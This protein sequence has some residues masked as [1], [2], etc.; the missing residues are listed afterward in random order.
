MDAQAD[1]PRTLASG[2]GRGRTISSTAQSLNAAPQR[3]AL[4]A[5]LQQEQAALSQ[6]IESLAASLPVSSTA[7]AHPRSGAASIS[8]VSIKLPP[9]WP[10][11]PLIWFAQAEAMFNTRRITQQQTKFDYVISSLSHEYAL[12]VRDLLLHPPAHNPYDVLKEK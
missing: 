11:D 12:E 6:R 2:T 9:F 1:N 7:E 4:V 5:Q 8:A 3:Q 10:P